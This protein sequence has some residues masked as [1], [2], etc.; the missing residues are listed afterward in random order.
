M[1]LWSY[2]DRYNQK[3]EIM[4]IYIAFIRMN[5]AVLATY[6]AL[7]EITISAPFRALQYWNMAFK[8]P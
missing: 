6:L 3:Y 5:T 2:I 7:L 1:S 4:R 8:R